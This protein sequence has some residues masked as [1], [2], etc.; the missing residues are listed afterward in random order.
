MVAKKN[1]DFMGNQTQIIQSTDT[2]FTG[3]DIQASSKDITH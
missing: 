3:Q 2:H 1:P